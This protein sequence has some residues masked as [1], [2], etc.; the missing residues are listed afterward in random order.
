MG[1]ARKL[2]A[3]NQEQS[4]TGSAEIESVEQ[5]NMAEELSR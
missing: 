2:A 5:S 4:I 1:V 3:A